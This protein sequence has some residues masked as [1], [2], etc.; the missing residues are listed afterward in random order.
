MLRGICF[1]IK[2]IA[3]FC[4][5]ILEKEMTGWAEELFAKALT[6]EIPTFP[7]VLLVFLLS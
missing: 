6:R 3:Q 4:L 1:C 7:F 2:I 5:F